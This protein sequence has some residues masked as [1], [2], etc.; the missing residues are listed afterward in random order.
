VESVSVLESIAEVAIALAGFGGIA[1]GL[2]YRARGAWAPD[3]QLRLMLLALTGLTVV[4]ACFLPHAAYHL[5]SDPPWRIAS[6]LFLPLPILGLF[7]TAR[8]TRGGLG[9]DYSQIAAWLTIATQISATA[10]LL[11]AAL[12]YADTRQFGLYLSAILLMLLQAGVFFVRLLATS[13]RSS[14]PTA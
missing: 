14:A 9:T 5:G 10:L 13:F 12:G 1:A 7:L 8:R 11:A 3:D 6:A 4:F 2:G